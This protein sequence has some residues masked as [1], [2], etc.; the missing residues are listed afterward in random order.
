MPRA[1]IFKLKPASSKPQDK[2]KDVSRFMLRLPK[3]SYEQLSQ[4]S[5]RN[6]RSMNAEINLQLEKLIA[7]RN[8]E[9]GAQASRASSNTAHSEEPSP[10]VLALAR[11]LQALPA[12]KQKALMTLLA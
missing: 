6:H 8:A 2:R 9:D 4:I 3:E 1:E 12:E 5:S 7:M 10:S 11:K